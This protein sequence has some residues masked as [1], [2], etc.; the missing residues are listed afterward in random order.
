MISRFQF[1]S[2]GR[3]GL[4]PFDR[5]RIVDQPNRPILKKQDADKTQASG[6]TLN[7]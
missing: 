5:G 2:P 4:D 6:A 7:R 1:I 3:R